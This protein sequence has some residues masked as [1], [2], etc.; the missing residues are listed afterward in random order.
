MILLR[1]IHRKSFGAGIVHVLKR[2][3]LS[4]HMNA[5]MP[6]AVHICSGSI[7]LSSLRGH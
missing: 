7:V 2:G 5:Q 6:N 3:E 4:A 1:I